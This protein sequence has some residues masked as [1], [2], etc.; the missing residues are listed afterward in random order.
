MPRQRLGCQKRPALGGHGL[1]L[2]GGTH[3]TL[4]FSGGNFEAIS[5]CRAPFSAPPPKAGARWGVGSLLYRSD[6]FKKES[7]YTFHGA[8][9]NDSLLR[10]RRPS[11]SPPPPHPPANPPSCHPPPSTVLTKLRSPQTEPQTEPSP[12]PPP[13]LLRSPPFPPSPSRPR[14]PAGRAPQSTAPVASASQ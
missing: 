6:F 1:M 12:L 8:R 4:L 9:C 10:I 11:A 13:S 3:G 2:E 7:V 14:P 5:G